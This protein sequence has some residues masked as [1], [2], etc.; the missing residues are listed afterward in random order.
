[1]RESRS[2]VQLRYNK[3]G[4]FVAYYPQWNVFAR[5]LAHKHDELCDHLQQV[6]THGQ[7]HYPRIPSPHTCAHTPVVSCLCNLGACA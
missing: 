4:E 2:I 1:M 7:R 5:D 6:R 3:A